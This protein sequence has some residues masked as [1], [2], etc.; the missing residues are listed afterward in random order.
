MYKLSFNVQDKCLTGGK[1]KRIIITTNGLGSG[2]L[3]FQSD[4]Y[5]TQNYHCIYLHS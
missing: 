4:D 5:V 2:N 1:T 3:N